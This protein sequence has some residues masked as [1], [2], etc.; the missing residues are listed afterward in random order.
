MKKVYHIEYVADNYRHQG[1]S[2]G[3]QDAGWLLKSIDWQSYRKTKSLSTLRNRIL[4]EV[5]SWKPD[6]VFLHLQNSEV[7]DLQTIKELQSMSKVVNYTFD[8]RGKGDVTFKWLMETAKHISLTCFSNQGDVDYC[9][10]LAC[11]ENTPRPCMVLQSSADFEFYHKVEPQPNVYPEIIFLGNNYRDSYNLGFPQAAQR[12]AMIDFLYETFGDRFCA[13]GL[14]QKGGY[15][16]NEQERIAYSTAKVTLTQNQ[17]NIPMYCSD[18]GWRSSAC[19]CMTIHEYYEGMPDTFQFWSNFDDLRNN[20]NFYLKE[21]EIRIN[22]AAKDCS[23]VRLNHSY[24]NRVKEL[25]KTLFEETIIE[26]RWDDYY[27]RSKFLDTENELFIP[28]SEV[29]VYRKPH[30]SITD[31]SDPFHT[32]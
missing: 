2:K 1:I 18:R 17:F 29:G 30:S 8:V 26:G 11:S 16:N 31:N 20:I 6:I 25:E 13:Y 27:G 19:G 24:K 12:Q 9:N 5:A 32:H 22:A 28:N 4:D 7:L 23:Y 15:L 21:D 10:A 14:G 3:F